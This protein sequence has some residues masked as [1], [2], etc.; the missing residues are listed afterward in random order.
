[1]PDFTMLKFQ[2][3]LNLILGISNYYSLYSLEKD[4]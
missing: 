2:D 4:S 1:M 3:F